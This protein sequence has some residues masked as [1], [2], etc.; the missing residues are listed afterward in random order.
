MT[1]TLT[2]SSHVQ[3]STFPCTAA[4]DQIIKARRTMRKLK[5]IH[6]PS[7][8]EAPLCT[9]P[10]RH[11][12]TR[13]DTNPRTQ[14]KTSFHEPVL[15]LARRHLGYTSTAV[16][17]EEGRWNI[18]PRDTDPQACARKQHHAD[19]KCRPAP[20]VRRE[21]GHRWLAQHHRRSLLQCQCHSL[22]V[23]AANIY[24][25]KVCVTATG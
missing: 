13:A 11:T 20:S 3:H 10:R 7:T 18:T 9:S 19:A 15:S 24:P 1:L 6:C 17:R 8:G 23:A 25:Y 14:N 5:P 22:T 21:K 16:K 4:H 12:H 2:L